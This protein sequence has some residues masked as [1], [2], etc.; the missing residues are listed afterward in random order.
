MVNVFNEFFVSKA[1][2]D[3]QLIQ[4]KHETKVKDKKTDG[5]VNY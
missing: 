5:N 2:A 3:D 1:S 4:W